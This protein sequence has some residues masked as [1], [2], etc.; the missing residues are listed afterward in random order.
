MIPERSRTGERLR[1]AARRLNLALA[2]DEPVPAPQLERAG[3]VEAARKRSLVR[4]ARWFERQDT[5]V[6]SHVSAAEGILPHLD[7][8]FRQHVERCALAP[9][10]SLFNDPR[11]R[12][13]F[14]ALTLS[15]A[16]WLRFT[17]V[18]WR[19]I[20]VAYHFGM[21]FGGAF[22]WYKPSFEPTL[23]QRSPG[24]MLLRHLLVAAFEE[25][26]HT[27]DFGIGDE[28]FKYR[29]ATSVPQVRTWELG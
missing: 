20:A 16:G 24:E 3:L 14:R 13:F 17:R 25:G 21:C 7:D 18:E 19:G 10:P 9:Y 12:D 23:A 27:F 5:V 2:R 29:F 1:T 28:A 15:D 8:F 6:V 26:A 22:I 11:Q 4:H